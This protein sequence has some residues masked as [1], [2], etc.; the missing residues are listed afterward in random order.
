MLNSSGNHTIDQRLVDIQRQMGAVLFD[1][2][3]RQDCYGTRPIEP[4]EV[5]AFEVGP[6]TRQAG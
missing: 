2:G 4:G 1:G 3:H 6:E 5:R